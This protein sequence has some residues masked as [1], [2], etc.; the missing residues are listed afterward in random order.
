M[1]HLVHVHVCSAVELGDYFWG[2]HRD[3]RL[4]ECE[5]IMNGALSLS[6]RK[7]YMVVQYAL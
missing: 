7:C 3:S 1:G 6:G 4:F 2:K 5:F